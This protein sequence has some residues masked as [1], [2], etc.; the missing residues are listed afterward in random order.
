MLL[1]T[2]QSYNMAIMSFT[3]QENIKANSHAFERR[4]TPTTRCM[5]FAARITQRATG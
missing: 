5:P 4:R 3:G 2:E 1:E